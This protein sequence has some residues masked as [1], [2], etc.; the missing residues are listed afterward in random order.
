[1][2]GQLS[3]QNTLSMPDTSI[4]GATATVN[5]QYISIKEKNHYM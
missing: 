5:Q 3:F 1:M 4:K 2:Q